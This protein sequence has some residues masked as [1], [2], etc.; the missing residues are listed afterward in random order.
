MKINTTK[1]FLLIFF[2]ILLFSCS[3]NKKKAGRQGMNVPVSVVLEEQNIEEV[4]VFSTNL[5]VHSLTYLQISD[6]CMIGEVNKL[7]FCGNKP[8]IYDRAQKKIFIFNEDGTFVSKIDDIGRGP[9]EYIQINDFCVLEETKSI[10]ALVIDGG[11]K[12]AVYEYDLEGGLKNRF[13]LPFIA[14]SIGSFG[15]YLA[16]YTDYSS[17]KRK[18]FNVYITTKEC[19]VLSKHF[20]YKKR[21]GGWGEGLVSKVFST[22]KN[23]LF[24]YPLYCDTIY[25]FV[26]PK[27]IEPYALLKGKDPS[28]M[29][30]LC[31][32][33]QN[34]SIDEFIALKRELKVWTFSSLLISDKRIFFSTGLDDVE[35]Q[36]IYDLDSRHLEL[37]KQGDY[38]SLICSAP[39]LFDR[40][41]L[42]SIIN[43]YDIHDFV[44]SFKER[45]S[46]EGWQNYKFDNKLFMKIYNATSFDDNPVIIRYTFT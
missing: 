10:F 17:G 41:H 39:L 30:E 40:G 6:D 44:S 7:M 42:I 9:K 1:Y 27:H 20:S 35:G 23:Q 18:D 34:V 25:R 36:Y 13:K 21:K 3:D 8:V 24:Y 38:I 31:G 32:L 14:Y 26:N 2:S 43:P 45:M 37:F 16:F 28:G 33:Y 19:K 22:S 15:N 5:S 46:P 4:E 12:C 29:Q 11:R